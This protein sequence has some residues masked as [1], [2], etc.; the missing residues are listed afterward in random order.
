MTK[1]KARRQRKL[2]AEKLAIERRLE[3]A[4]VVNPDLLV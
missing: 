3:C 2:T 1:A 4:V